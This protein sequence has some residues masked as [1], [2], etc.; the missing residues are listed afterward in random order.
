MEQARPKL[1]IPKQI[2]YMECKGI[3]FDIM[4]K[5]D[6]ASFL[7]GHNYYF[8]LK[9]YAK[10]YHKYPDARNG[11]Y[12][13]L[14]FAYLVELSKLD[15]YFRKQ[16]IAMALD[17]EHY[18]KSQMLS[19]MSGDQSEDGYA[20]VRDFLARDEKIEKS[21]EEKSHKSYCKDLVSKYKENYAI[22]HL[23]E[24]L[25]FNHFIELYHYYYIVRRGEAGDK[26]Y[27]RLKPVKFLRNA[28]AHNNCLFNSLKGQDN[29][30]NINLNTNSKIATIKGISAKSRA[31]KMH[32]RTIH[33]FV[34]LV[35]LF[36]D[37][38]PPKSREY[39]LNA[40]KLFFDET[41]I[42]NKSYFLMNENLASAYIFTKKVVDYYH[43][44]SI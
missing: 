10:N 20:I 35:D 33:D 23:V 8:K 5:A 7:D 15:S 43:G 1:T 28:A 31:N 42:R 11:T 22:W 21:I 34:V 26:I 40:L 37:V 30:F 24:V 44:M 14:D 16:V 9:A 19:D 41:L 27:S 12:K 25:S 36:C 18:L 38:A 29:E 13:N 3:K 39:T 17:L 6:A 4:T 32:N 2:E